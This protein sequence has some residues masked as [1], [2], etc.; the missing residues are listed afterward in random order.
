MVLIHVEVEDL[1]LDQ[2][3]VFSL[4]RVL[5]VENVVNAA[6][7]SPDVNLLAEGVLF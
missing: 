2:S 6:T 4:E 1:L 5:L 3:G 7:Q